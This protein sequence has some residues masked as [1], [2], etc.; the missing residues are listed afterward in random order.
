MPA[1]LFA[2]PPPT[3]YPAGNLVLAS[4]C[5]FVLLALVLLV[6]GCAPTLRT[7]DEGAL[8]P[9]DAPSLEPMVGCYRYL[10]NSPNCADCGP[11]PFFPF[12]EAGAPE[13]P[14]KSLPDTREP[15]DT[16]C[17]RASE[18][19]PVLTATSYRSGVAVRSQS[20][21]GHTRDDGYFVI[22]TT[23]D[24]DFNYT[25]IF[26]VMDRGRAALSVDETGA[27]QQLELRSSVLFFVIVPAYGADVGASA[28]FERAPDPRSPAMPSQ[29]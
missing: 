26:W 2:V 28:R 11:V 1:V 24:V 27:L 3:S 4:A 25:V 10:G 23:T 13:A 17:L 7:A 21:E 6:A 18:D 20:Y 12:G 9:L 16:V 19:G 5:A 14:V 15:P 29:P 8:Q 22:D